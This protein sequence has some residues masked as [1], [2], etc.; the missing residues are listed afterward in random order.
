MSAGASVYDL[1]TSLLY[2]I[3]TISDRR[4]TG[5]A[6]IRGGDEREQLYSGHCD[7]SGGP[8]RTFHERVTR[9][10]HVEADAIGQ[11]RTGRSDLGR[12]HGAY[13]TRPDSANSAGQTSLAQNGVNSA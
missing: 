12:K 9:I 11:K 10:A 8:T 5:W 13:S 3:S 1:T 7:S 4:P 6:T 2:F